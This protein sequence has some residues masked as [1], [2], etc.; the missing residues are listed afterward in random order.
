M[1]KADGLCAGKGVTICASA[2]EAQ[3]VAASF[4]GDEDTDD[5]PEFGDA[6]RRIIIEEFL[7][8]DELSILGL[9]DG[10][11]ALLFAPARDHKQLHDG[12]Q[13][14]NTGGM[15]AVAPLTDAHGISS[16]FLESVRSEVFLPV[17]REMKRRGSPYRGILY[18]GLMYSP[19]R[20]AVL[21]FNCRFG[22]PEA[23]A[24]LMGTRCDL[25][26]LFQTVANE[27]P[28]PDNR[29]DLVASCRPTATVVLASAGYP[30]QPESGFPIVLDDYV[31]SVDEKIFYAGVAAQGDGLKTAG[32]RV[33]A[34]SASANNH[35]D[36]VDRAYQLLSHIDFSGSQYRQDIGASLFSPQP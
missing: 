13:G 17:L 7:L 6:S 19:T 25:L 21:E 4:L 24:V 35:R 2:Q 26:P 32:G 18:A 29:P 16:A 22:D 12:G 30:S 9:C 15:G 3:R 14:P 5:T 8:G 23:Q 34:C 27:Q 10:E 36:A 33:L 31:P 11:D 20:T 28:L 1:V